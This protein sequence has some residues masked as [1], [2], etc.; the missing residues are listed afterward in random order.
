MRLVGEDALTL[1]AGT[2][3]RLRRLALAF[4]AGAVTALAF[5]PTHMAPVLLLTFPLLFVLLEP[6]TS[7]TAVRAFWT[8]WAFG[9][10]FH[11]VG[12]HWIG[13]AFLV[14]ADVFAWALPFAVTLLPAGLAIFFGLAGVAVALAWRRALWRPVAFI[15]A[16][17]LAEWLRSVV[18][19]GFPWNVVGYALAWPLELMQAIAFVGL[20]GLTVL[21]LVIA[22]SPFLVW[23]AAH[24]L[25]GMPVRAAAL[26]VATAIVPLATLFILGA[27]R[28]Q[29]IEIATLPDVRL[30]LVQPSIDQT[31][32]WQPQ[33]QAEI[34]QKHLDMTRG[35]ADAPGSAAPLEGAG[36]THILWAEA[37][38]PFRPLESDYALSKLAKIVPDGVPLIAGVLRSEPPA[39]GMAAAGAQRNVFNSAV[40]FDTDAKATS[41]YD[42]YHLVPF[43]EYLPFPALFELIGFETLVRQ[44]GGFTP[45]IGRRKPISIPGL[46]P[47]EMLICYEAIFPNEVAAGFNRPGLLINLTNDGWFGDLTGPYQHFHQTRARAVE[48]GLPLVRVSNNGVSAV[49]GPAGRLHGPIL[50]LNAVAIVDVDVPQAIA[51]TLYAEWRALPALLI[52]ALILLVALFVDLKCARRDGMDV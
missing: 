45:A 3:A 33:K 8:A 24:R 20:H 27:M 47:V 52:I 17:T 48:Q 36:V 19:T 22:L 25:W 37:A 21:C 18:L 13:N 16:V 1:S 10:G 39:R 29:A 35:G 7:K 41:V 11:I 26:A 14:Q 28:L 38:M 31:E 34:F 12:L 42:K 15:L 43:G 46:P 44:R 32:K 9:F 40:V 2:R 4:G 51:P 23:R 30:R 5:A 49:I 6:E 50:S